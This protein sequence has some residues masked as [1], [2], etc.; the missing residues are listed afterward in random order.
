[1][2][3]NSIRNLGQTGG[4]EVPSPQTAAAAPQLEPTE[5]PEELQTLLR[6]RNTL[7]RQMQALTNGTATQSS[8]SEDRRY[9]IASMA[10]RRAEDGA[11]MARR[12]DPRTPQT[13]QDD[14]TQRLSRLR[15][16]GQELKDVLQDPPERTGQRA[17]QGLQ[18]KLVPE[19]TSQRQLPLP[20][21]GLMDIAD[22]GRRLLDRR[23][24]RLSEERPL[25]NDPDQRDFAPRIPVPKTPELKSLDDRLSR[26]RKRLDI[27]EGGSG[28][29]DRLRDI[30]RE[31]L[32]DR[33]GE[34]ERDDKRDAARRKKRQ[35]DQAGQ[36]RPTQTNDDKRDAARLDRR[37][38]G[39]GQE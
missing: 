29:L 3:R 8:D 18:D 26:A 34:S 9:P 19:R 32:L 5:M 14:P 2:P 21:R 12:D 27:L 39:K 1:M 35:D 33:R 30:A 23:I 7:E 15:S 28:N 31:R 37:G 17:L 22:R 4:R 16:V 11:W 24:D 25:P 6:E 36:S 20:G 38:S 10:Q 13:G